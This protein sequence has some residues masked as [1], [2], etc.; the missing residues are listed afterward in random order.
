MGEDFSPCKRHT[1]TGN[2]HIAG[3]SVGM[4][5][6]ADILDTGQDHRPPGIYRLRDVGPEAGT[7]SFCPYPVMV[8]GC[9]YLCLHCPGGDKQKSSRFLKASCT[10]C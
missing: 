7:R 6:N 8:G 2:R 3:Q 5:C 10:F 9:C 4:G 1:V